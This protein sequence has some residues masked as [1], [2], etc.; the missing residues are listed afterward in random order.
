MRSTKAFPLR[1]P[2]LAA[3]A[4]LLLTVTLW[5]RPVAASS[6][7]GRPLREMIEDARAH[8]LA[9]LYST[10]LI[11]DPMH[12][13]VEPR[14]L[15]PVSRLQETL[16]PFG[17][18]LRRLPNSGYAIV[19]DPA[20]ARKTPP[21]EKPASTEQILDEILVQSHL[22]RNARG[23][24]EPKTGIPAL[25]SPGS[26]SVI[27]VSPMAE[28]NPQTLTEMLAYTAGVIGE[29]GAA[30]RSDDL[31]LMRGFPV[32]RVFVDGMIRKMSSLD[33]TTEPYGL[34]RVEVLK[35]PVSAL[36]GQMEP[37]GIVNAITK[38]PSETRLHELQVQT[39]S[40]AQTRFAADSSG[41]LDK[42]GKWLFRMTALGRNSQTSVDFTADNRRYL[43][44]AVT[45]RISDRSSFTLLT[46]YQRDETNYHVGLP[47]AGTVDFNPNG[48][49]PTSRNPGEPSDFLTASG[50][51]ASGLFESRLDD[52]WTLRQ[53]IRYSGFNTNFRTTWNDGF[54][55]DQRTLDRELE[56][57]SSRDD[58]FT[59]DNQLLG[60]FRG[61]HL[62]HRLLIGLDYQNLVHRSRSQRATASPLDIFAPVYG[63]PVGP[64]SPSCGEDA[65]SAQLGLYVSDQLKLNDKWVW[66]FGGRFDTVRHEIRDALSETR[67]RQNDRAVTRRVGW[68]YRA[69]N[70]LAPYMSFSD[71]FE[72]TVGLDS[73]Q[74]PYKPTNGRQYEAGIRY[75]PDAQPFLITTAIYDLRKRREPIPDP[76][77]D[78]SNLQ[79]GESRSRGIELE[80]RLDLTPRF[81][82]AAT[83]AHTE[84]TIIKGASAEG[85]ARRR[86]GVPRETATLWMNY[87]L[88][89]VR[90]GLGARYV[91]RSPGTFD[92]S[93]D[94]H[95]F[96]VADLFVGYT[97]G[98]W[99]LALFGN[100]IFDERYV[101][102]CHYGCFYGRRR[103]IVGSVA[104]RWE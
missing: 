80:T 57:G 91:G 55:A 72:P 20:L 24:T 78:V 13:T 23:A 101:E 1:A 27:P 47:G 35:G 18:T 75:A 38:R 4:L 9:V 81:N 92:L 49:I 104:Y 83:Y 17:L 21:P 6:W 89:D 87:S 84:A 94:T 25:E 77:F 59:V 28:R 82:L 99:N 30:N 97:A 102:A 8:G 95:S 51:A 100:N 34:E 67:I 43:A 40:F 62:E 56:A 76:R 69:S 32:E 85:R 2:Q 103:E 22:S 50:G 10:D 48:I 63:G 54:E 44:P 37:G 73:N 60:I 90:I 29:E 41:P 58:A 16:A 65:Q 74:L 66:L 14:A 96:T 12:V 88:R 61:N 11:G 39:G 64:L 42:D 68:V 52:A 36:F 19:S 86:A 70:G 46:S 33:F 79:K 26:I 93:T 98:R 71:S 15:D 31:L 45:W 7:V 5:A 3:T 53:S